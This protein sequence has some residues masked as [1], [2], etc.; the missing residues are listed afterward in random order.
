MIL[1]LYESEVSKQRL[2]A[3]LIRLDE[4]TDAFVCSLCLG[5]Q[6]LQHGASDPTALMFRQEGDVEDADLVV[7]AIH[8][9]AAHRGVPVQDDVIC[10]VGETFTIGL[11]LGVKLKGEEGVLPGIVPGYLR[12]LVISRTRIDGEQKGFVARKDWAEGYSPVVIPLPQ[13]G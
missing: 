4:D 8:I 12:H 1:F 9:Q 5:Q 7:T 3:L 13:P 6:I 10:G 11:M 2:G